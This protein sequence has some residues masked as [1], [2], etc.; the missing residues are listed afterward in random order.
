MFPE[1]LVRPFVEETVK[2]PLVA[3]TGESHEISEETVRTAIADK[4]KFAEHVVAHGTKKD[5]ANFESIK[6][7]L[8]SIRNGS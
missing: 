3:G 8:D 2:R 4:R 7:K 5:F 1:A 6:A